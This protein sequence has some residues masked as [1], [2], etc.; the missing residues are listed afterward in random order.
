AFLVVCS[1]AALT[2]AQIAFGD[3]PGSNGDP[4]PGIAVKLVSPNPTSNEVRVAVSAGAGSESTIIDVM[5]YDVRGR[6]VAGQRGSRRV[7][8]FQ[9]SVKMAPDLP[10]G[11]YFLAVMTHE[12]QPEGTRRGPKENI[13]L[14][15]RI[16]LIE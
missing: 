6:E 13:I 12:A 11:I 15:R 4:P 2:V 14:S 16:V 10:S 3:V 7:G 8:E 9:I 5:I 1:V